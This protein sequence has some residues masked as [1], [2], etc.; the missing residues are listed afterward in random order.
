MRGN[1]GQPDLTD[2]FAL[3]VEEDRAGQA[4]P[5]SPPFPP[6]GDTPHRIHRPIP[7]SRWTHTVPALTIEVIDLPFWSL[8]AVSRTPTGPRPV[9]SAARSCFIGG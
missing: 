5:H 2:L 9:T 7:G 8:R 6:R 4:V 3:R 1:E